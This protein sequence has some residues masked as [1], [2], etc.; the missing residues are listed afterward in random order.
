MR[1]D[2]EYLKK[3]LNVFR[4]SEKP[5]VDYT[6][7]NVAGLPSD[8]KLIFHIQLL[9][10]ENLVRPVS[11]DNYDL[12][13]MIGLDGNIGLSCIPIRMTSAGHSFLEALNNENIWPKFKK[14][15]GESSLAVMASVASGLLTA[16]L[17]T[18][19]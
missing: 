14:K 2:P 13:V 4:D 1:V 8:E 6:D 5:W 11:V 15:A 3:L 18:L 17:Q 19:I 9:A 16:S 7:I 10:D 12:G